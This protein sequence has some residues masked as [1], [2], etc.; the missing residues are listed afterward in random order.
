MTA[1]GDNQPTRKCR[2]LVPVPILAGVLAVIG[3]VVSAFSCLD[4][5]VR[6]GDRA[7]PEVRPRARAV[8]GH[9]HR[10]GRRGRVGY[11]GDPG[12]HTENSPTPATTRC[13]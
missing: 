2:R 9:R 4:V 11:G 1:S 13:R 6:P 8:P 7:R 12:T 3:A 5:V 10:A